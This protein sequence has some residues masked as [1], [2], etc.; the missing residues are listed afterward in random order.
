MWV[1]QGGCLWNLG[2][3]SEPAYTNTLSIQ[4]C[5]FPLLIQPYSCLNP[6]HLVP[7]SY[8]HTL[9]LPIHPTLYPIYPTPYTLN[10]THYILLSAC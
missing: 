5:L 7:H 2:V 3:W 1:Q 9:N 10:P 6:L 4:D 8:P